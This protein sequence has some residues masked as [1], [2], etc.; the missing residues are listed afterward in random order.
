MIKLT[1]DEVRYI[2]NNYTKGQGPTLGF[3]ATKFKRSEVA[4]HKLVY[5]KSYR[6]VD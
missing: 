6:W 3:F 4:I 1:E 5:R 2:R